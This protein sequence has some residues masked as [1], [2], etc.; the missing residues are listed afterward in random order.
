LAV[1]AIFLYVGAEVAI[2]SFMVIY[3]S[4][5]EIG[6][7]S[8]THAAY[9][10]SLYWGGAMVG[11]FVGAGLLRRVAPGRLL[12]VFAVC[13]GILVVTSSFS[14]GLVA[15]V[16]I[17]A[18]GL[19][20]SIMFPT[21]FSLGVADLKGLTPQA[22]SL[23]GLAIVGGAIVPM[24]QGMLADRWGLQVALLAPVLCYV[25][26]AYFGFKGSRPCVDGVL[27]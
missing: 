19:F 4:Q 27:P 6:G 8:H 14:H 12:G 25:Y 22:S 16:A 15:V 10:L 24:V 23:I 11:R 9:A 21:I 26:I 3:L 5:P 17:I 13:A 1:F 20:N 2:G 7:F 18:V